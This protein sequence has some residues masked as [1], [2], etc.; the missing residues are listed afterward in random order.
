MGFGMITLSMK[1]DYGLRTMLHVASYGDNPLI[2]IK[3]MAVQQTIPAGTL[4]EIVRKLEQAGLLRLVREP[5][6]RCALTRP[7]DQ[8]T[9]GDVIKA[10]EGRIPAVTIPTETIKSSETDQCAADAVLTEMMERLAD[11]FNS[12]TLNDLHLQAAP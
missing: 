5:F 10:I 3:D 9:A 2:V 4:R 1:S 8:I 11:Y 6:N 12:V 7:A